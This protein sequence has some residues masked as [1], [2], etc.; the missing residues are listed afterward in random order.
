MVL[1][2]AY[3]P[4]QTTAD[5]PRVSPFGDKKRRQGRPAKRW[6]DDLD[7][8]WSNTIW[9]RTPHDRLTLRR[10]AD[11]FA[12]PRDTTAAQ[13]WDE[14][15]GKIWPPIQKSSNEQASPAF[16][17]YC[18]KLCWVGQITRHGCRRPENDQLVGK[19]NSPRTPRRPSQALTSMSP[20]GKPVSRIDPCGGVD[21]MITPMMHTPS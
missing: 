7:K 12:Q 13:W 5:G 8:Y 3:Q 16:T 10:H 15:H 21:P 17:L 6:R 20:T 14:L 1:D 18:R 19:M 2:R 4:P 9:Q 11:A